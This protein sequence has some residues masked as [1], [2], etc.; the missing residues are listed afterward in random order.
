[1]PYAS[2][3]SGIGR[4]RPL[5][6]NERPFDDSASRQYSQSQT[7]LFSP[8]L[9]RQQSVMTQTASERENRRNTPRSNQSR[10]S[11]SPSTSSMND[12]DRTSV[13]PIA[14]NSHRRSHHWGNTAM[15]PTPHQN[16]FYQHEQNKFIENSPDQHRSRSID[17]LGYTADF[18][19]PAQLSN[20]NIQ[21]SSTAPLA[22]P[23][24]FAPVNTGAMSAGNNIH[25]NNSN[26]EAQ[27]AFFFQH[28]EINNDGSSLPSAYFA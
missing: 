27:S 8:Q 1:L 24:L 26:R 3:H 12:N 22:H 25:A 10:Y 23:L 16:L 4:T 2:L 18:N 13:S 15:T 11:N 20:M 21:N 5:D 28:F 6:E 14:S 7:R 19:F 17:T 9:S